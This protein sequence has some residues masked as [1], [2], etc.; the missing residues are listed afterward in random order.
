MKFDKGARDK[1]DIWYS[2]ESWCDT[3]GDRFNPQNDRVYAEE[4]MRKDDPSLQGA[5]RA[6]QQQRAPG[7]MIHMTVSSRSGGCAL[8][9]VV[10]PAKQTVTSKFYVD[11]V[12]KAVLPQIRSKTLD[13]NNFF[14]WQ[15][16]LASAHTAV[17]TQKY[18][19]AEKVVAM[20][21]MPKG[22]DCSPLDFFVWDSVKEEL[23]R[24]PKESRNTLRKLEAT[25]LH[26]VEKLRGDPDWVRKLRKAC[27]SVPKRMRWVVNTGGLE[28][29]GKPWRKAKSTA[30][31]DKKQNE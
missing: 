5:L 24:T 19:K 23:K 16:D 21:W 4:K 10:V 28:I 8:P 9:P 13:N 17:D 15:E 14:V 27:R 12:L 11:D 7:V 31:G 25:L 6:P 26:T 20:P 22:A 3:N 18:L 30:A 1:D 29:K 2:D